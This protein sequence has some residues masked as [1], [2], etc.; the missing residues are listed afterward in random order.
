[1][2]LCVAKELKMLDSTRESRDIQ[3]HVISIAVTVPMCTHV[4]LKKV[5]NFSVIINSMQHTV[6]RAIIFSKYGAGMHVT[7]SLKY[8]CTQCK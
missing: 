5:C 2:I 7:S 8:I 1:M 3:C 6:S 4:T